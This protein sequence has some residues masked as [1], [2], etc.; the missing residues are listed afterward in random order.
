MEERPVAQVGGKDGAAVFTTAMKDVAANEEVSDEPIAPGLISTPVSFSVNEERIF[1]GK[2]QESKGIEVPIEPTA[3][4]RKQKI[5]NKQRMIQEIAANQL[6]QEE[7]AKHDPNFACVA[8]FLSRVCGT[9]K[10]TQKLQDAARLAIQKGV[11]QDVVEGVTGEVAKGG[12]PT[13]AI[14]A[15]ATDVEAGAIE[16]VECDDSTVLPTTVA[17]LDARQRLQLIVQ[18][19]LCFRARPLR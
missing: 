1:T 11:T 18:R 16:T 17:I 9:G 15:A 3:L 10:E 2:N 8:S 6:L 14:V 19:R 12:L 4:Q 5:D 13:F 7:L